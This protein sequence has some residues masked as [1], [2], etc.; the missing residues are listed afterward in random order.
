MPSKAPRICQCGRVT[1]AGT[2]CECQIKRDKER[3]ARFEASRPSARQRGYDSKWEQARADF[4]AR[5]PV[6]VKCPDPATIV[7]HKT[8]HKGD[9]RLFW[10]R[11]NWQPLCVHC[12]SSSKQREERRT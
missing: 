2:R 4:L 12:H 10:D 8:P 11:K 9:M 7:D 3:K 5:N 6:C 1:P